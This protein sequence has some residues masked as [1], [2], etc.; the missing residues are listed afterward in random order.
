MNNMEL[1]QDD[2]DPRVSWLV[3]LLFFAIV[4]VLAAR[5]FAKRRATEAAKPL[6]KKKTEEGPD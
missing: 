5:V 3:F 4:A 2:D 1:P 6:V